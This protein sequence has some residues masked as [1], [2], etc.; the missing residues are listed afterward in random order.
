M[1]HLYLR[2]DSNG[3]PYV[4]T[5]KGQTYKLASA[6]RTWPDIVGAPTAQAIELAKKEG[7]A[8]I[9]LK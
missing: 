3:K 6:Q 9:K 4:V 2:F 5:P 8:V 7:I 1:T